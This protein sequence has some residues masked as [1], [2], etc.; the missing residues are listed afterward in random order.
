MPINK[1]LAAIRVIEPSKSL[2]KVL[3]A[4]S[5]DGSVRT[6]KIKYRQKAPK[7][8]KSGSKKVTGIFFKAGFNVP[9]YKSRIPIKT[10]TV[11][12][13]IPSTNHSQSVTLFK[14]GVKPSQLRMK[15]IRYS[16][17]A[18]R[19]KLLDRILSAKGTLIDLMRGE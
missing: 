4:I 8:I 17:D 19:Y 13:F 10:A 5:N 14:L 16:E 1:S 6:R 9:R 18:N 7:I 12:K 2:P 15:L 11:I 3:L